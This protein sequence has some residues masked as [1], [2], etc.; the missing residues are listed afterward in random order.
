MKRLSL[1]VMLAIMTMS[2]VIGAGDIAS[3]ESRYFGFIKKYVKRDQVFSFESFSA[4]ILW[5]VLYLTPAVRDA[6]WTRESWI[7]EKSAEIHSVVLPAS[8]VR[9]TQFVMGMYSP[10]GTEAFDLTPETFWTMKLD[11]NGNEYTPIAIEPL[12][13]SPLIKRLIPFTH[14]WAK[15]YLVTFAGDFQAPFN[16]RM[17]GATAKGVIAIK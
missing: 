3:S 5:G 12:P 15:L 17:V 9:G 2:S 16:L 14:H 6:M 8:K 11:Q 10:K 13:N 1:V 4:D 7:T